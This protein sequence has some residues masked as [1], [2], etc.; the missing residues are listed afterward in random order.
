MTKKSYRKQYEDNF[1][2]IFIIS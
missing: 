1:F 2:E